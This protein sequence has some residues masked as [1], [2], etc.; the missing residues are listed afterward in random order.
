[1]G[2]A[3]LPLIDRLAHLFVF[4]LG[5]FWPGERVLARSGGEGVTPAPGD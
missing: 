4:G 5:E 2:R 3:A 1:M